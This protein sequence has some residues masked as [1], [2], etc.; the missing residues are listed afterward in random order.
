[1]LSQIEI[2]YSEYTHKVHLILYPGYFPARLKDF[3]TIGRML[4]HLDEQKAREIA[5][6]IALHIKD[7]EQDKY[8]NP[9]IVSRQWKYWMRY[10]M[11]YLRG[12]WEDLK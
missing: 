9:K 10:M 11:P 5:A 12:P 1:M 2:K 4:A 3:R 7:Y 8:S 6:D